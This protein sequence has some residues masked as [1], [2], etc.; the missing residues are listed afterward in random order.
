MLSKETDGRRLLK[1]ADFQRLHRFRHVMTHFVQ[2][3]QTYVVEEVLESNWRTFEDGLG[4]ICDIDQLYS[5][6]TSYLKNI[7]FM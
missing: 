3:F 2:T 6:H 7:L 4:R 1:S 5:L